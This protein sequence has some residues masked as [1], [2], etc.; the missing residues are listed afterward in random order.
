[1]S[2]ANDTPAVAP[3]RSAL[4]I[5]FLVV[6]IDLLGFAIVLPLLPRIAKVYLAGMQDVMVGLT[7]GLLFSSFSA[8]QF[9]FAPLWG[10]LSDRIGRRPVMLIGLAGSV[11]FYAVFG[12]A[13]TI[14]PEQSQLA[15]ILMFASRIGAGVA[16]ATI[17]TAAAAI[18]DCTPPEQRKRGMALIGAAFGVGFTFGPLIAYV[19][20]IA[21]PQQGHGAVGYVAAGLSL[22]AFLL[23]LRMLKETRVPGRPSEPRGWLHLDFLATFRMPTIGLLIATYFLATFAMANLESTLS[24]FTEDAYRYTDAENALVFAYVGFTLAFVQ[25]GIY[26]PLAKRVSEVAFIRMGIAFM[27]LGLGGLGALAATAVSGQHTGTGSLILLLIALAVA[28][29]GFA[30]MNP[31]VSALVS[32][33]A[34]ADRQGEVLGVNQSASALGRILGPVM[35]LTMFRLTPNHALPYAVSSAMLLIVLGLTWRMES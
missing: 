12:Y 35:A 2:N 21:L 29:T 3:P 20:L 22:I 13:A 26:R 7:I 25:G 34:P 15:L 14:S 23:G 8:M 19:A 1:M 27:L 4:L 28:V 9:L 30:F 11:V 6:V 32:R 31:S 33:R 17:S 18:A 5:I 16:G 10:R 24:L